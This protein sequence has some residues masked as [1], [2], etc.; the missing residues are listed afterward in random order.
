MA[1][2]TTVLFVFG[3]RP[4]AIK[5][6]PA[7]NCVRE[8]EGMRAVVA[9]TAQHREMLDQVLELF[10]IVPEYDLD[11]MRE[12]Q[13]PEEVLARALVE[14]S[15]LIREV[16]PDI[17]L[18][19]GDTTTTLAGALAA[20]YTHVPV[21]HLEAGLRTDD[22]SSPF[23]EEGNR[24]LVSQVATLSFAPTEHAAARLRAEGA[25]PASVI[26]T[27]NT[28][29][30]AVMDV[31]ERS[32]ELPT[33]LATLPGEGRRL[34]VVTLH[35]R[36]SWGAP[37]EEAC[38]GIRDALDATPDLVVVLPVHR[39][40]VVAETVNRVLGN[41]ERAV[42]TEPLGYVEFVKLLK[43]CTIVLSDSGGLQEEAAALGKPLLLLRETTERPEGAEAGTLKLVG[44]D[45]ATV[46]RETIALLGDADVYQA[47]AGAPNPFGDGHAAEKIIDAIEEYLG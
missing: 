18:V 36:E 39:N 17:V 1:V 26:M 28:V 40:P 14:L 29:I 38:L 37:L 46:A 21:G 8:R 16:D 44:T 10:E 19:Q 11:L 13:L 7:I 22:L 5:M 9:V 2:T 31:A 23:P 32:V 30:D 33:L 25:S 24:R 12:R 27:G 41:H 45:R 20:F 35:R 6:A 4:E 43:K 42:L 34:A 47:M 3:T 15:T